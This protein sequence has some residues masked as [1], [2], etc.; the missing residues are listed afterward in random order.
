MALILALG[1]VAFWGGAEG[2]EKGKEVKLTGTVTCA[3]CDYATVKAADPELKKPTACQTVIIAKEK[4]KDVV[5]YFDSASHKKYHDPVCRG[6][7]EGTVNGTC[8]LKDGKRVVTA[9]EVKLK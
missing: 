4:G 8:V 3:K 2:G 9:T 7:K 5:Y 1:L 6:A